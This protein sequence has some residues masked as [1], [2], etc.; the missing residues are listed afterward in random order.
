MLNVS[1]YIL[2]HPSD[3]DGYGPPYSLSLLAGLANTLMLYIIKTYFG[4]KEV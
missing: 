3:M 2:M 1:M 4:E